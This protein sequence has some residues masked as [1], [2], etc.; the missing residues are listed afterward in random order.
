MAADKN[1]QMSLFEE[2]EL[3]EIQ[4]HCERWLRKVRLRE[5]EWM[6]SRNPQDE[7]LDCSVNVF[8]DKVAG[9]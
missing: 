4:W 6:L 8:R 3:L 7:G 2:R 9:R 5:L 1:G